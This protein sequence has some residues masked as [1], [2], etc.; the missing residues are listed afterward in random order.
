M[1]PIPARPNPFSLQDD[2]GSYENQLIGL[3][4]FDI[5]QVQHWQVGH[6]TS[7]ASDK[8]P[9]GAAR[10]EYD[11]WQGLVLLCLGVCTWRYL[12]ITT[13]E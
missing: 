2:S 10:G 9:A 12:K 11:T 5:Q 1:H 7:L 3:V 8:Y 6:V 4:R 13:S